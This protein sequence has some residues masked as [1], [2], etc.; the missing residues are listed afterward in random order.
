[1]YSTMMLITFII[2]DGV[3]IAS[4][5]YVGER[6][7]G[8]KKIKLPLKIKLISIFAFALGLSLFITAELNVEETIIKNFEIYATISAG[9]HGEKVR[10]HVK[11]PDRT[12]KT[13][14]DSSL[15]GAEED[16]VK[17]RSLFGYDEYDLYL[18]NQTYCELYRSAQPRS[19]VITVEGEK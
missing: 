9:N 14:N 2:M 11:L 16:I 18:T 7:I 3:I 19:D 10:F 8:G 5:I 4:L 13:L 15:F 1:M 6:F 17:K 12:E